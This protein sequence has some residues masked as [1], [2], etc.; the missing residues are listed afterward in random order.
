MITWLPRWIACLVLAPPLVPVV[1]ADP[2][3]VEIAR[4][5]KQLG[6]DDFAK[7]EAATTRLEEMGESALD[8]L[9]KAC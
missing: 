2:D 5:I 9:D 7:R 8:A 1:A 3:D 4:L 6:D